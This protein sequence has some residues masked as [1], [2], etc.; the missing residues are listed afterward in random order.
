MADMGIIIIRQSILDGLPPKSAF[1]HYQQ[2]K[3]QSTLI[4]MMWG[5]FLVIFVITFPTLALGW[6][7]SPHQPG[8][9]NDADFWFLIQSSSMAVLSIFMMALP[10]WNGNNLQRA[11][12]T[13]LWLFMIVGIIA[14]L[15]A[16]VMYLYVPTEWSA[17]LSIL[18]GTVQTF[19]TLQLA[20]TA[21]AATNVRLKED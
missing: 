10:I 2:P 15:I 5:T 19:A 8:T 3:P 18:A 11:S 4:A 9:K 21:E 7:H 16:P 6:M 12:K 17:F 20:L 1:I 13:S 14:A